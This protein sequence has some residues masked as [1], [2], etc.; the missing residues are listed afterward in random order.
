[1]PSGMEQATSRP[2]GKRNGRKG[3]RGSKRDKLTVTAEIKLKAP[4]VPHGPRF[5]AYEDVLVQD[6]RI[7]VDVVLYRRERWETP[8]GERIVAPLPAGV[9]GGFGPE[10]RRFILASHIQGQVTAER[11]TALLNG[12]G[13]IISKRQV[14]RFLSQGLQGLEGEDQA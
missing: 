4:A 11:L 8:H 5:K 7:Q 10:L 9:V 3:G 12:M 2:G 14:V 6:L 1:K 13:L